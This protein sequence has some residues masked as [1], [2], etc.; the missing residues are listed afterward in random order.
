MRRK[1]RERE[2]RRDGE[3]ES[4]R[5]L[6]GLMIVSLLTATSCSSRNAEP[7]KPTTIEE[8]RAR[9]DLCAPKNTAEGNLPLAIRSVTH[10]AQATKVTIVAAAVGEP[11]D[12]HL[13]VYRLSSG[14][15]LINGT[16]RSYLLDE[17][18]REY[19]LKDRKS[20]PG[21]EIPLEGLIRLKAEQR[22]EAVLVFPRVSERSRVG[23][24][25]YDG[26]SLALVFGPESR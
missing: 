21:F 7:V 23:M 13:P 22:F 3:T 17:D 25:V 5:S 16:G 4:G 1:V 9:L 18:C 10:E 20:Q 14:R 26:R 8:A 6:A 2:R 12:F 15:W 11:V 19:K 24:L